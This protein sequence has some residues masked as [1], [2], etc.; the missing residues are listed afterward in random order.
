MT[1]PA[2]CPRCGGR[3][4]KPDIGVGI[5]C[6]RCG[7]VYPTVNQEPAMSDS[8]TKGPERFVALPVT[9]TAMQWD[10]TRAGWYRLSDWLGHGVLLAQGSA[11][12][13]APPRYLIVPTREGET[14]LVSGAW[15]VRGLEGELYPCADSVFRAKYASVRQSDADVNA[16]LAR[17]AQFEALAREAAGSKDENGWQLGVLMEIG[18]ELAALAPKTA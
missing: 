14:R 15:L 6:R 12:D 5:M 1:M 18:D 16:Q 7:V 11:G 2:N 4:A 3:A 10:G 9:I 13:A 8:D 17:L